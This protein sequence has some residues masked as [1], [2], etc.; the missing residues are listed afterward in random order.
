MDL[1]VPHF[2]TS[3]SEQE[4]C[5][6]IVIQSDTFAPFVEMDFEDAD[7]IFSDNF[8]TNSNERPITIRLDKQDIR[9][10]AF[11]DAEDLKN[12]LVL[13]SVADTF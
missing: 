11:K 3:V 2:T 6:E 4:D 1:Q 10:G 7:A 9:Q 5:F 8:F 12:R 13:T